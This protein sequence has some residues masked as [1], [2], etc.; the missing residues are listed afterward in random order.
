MFPS[1]RQAADNN[2]AWTADRRTQDCRAQREIVCVCLDA[3]H[4]WLVGPGPSKTRAKGN[5]RLSRIV[6][7]GQQ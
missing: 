4:G 3:E 5:N 1:V 2:Q 6:V 7:G